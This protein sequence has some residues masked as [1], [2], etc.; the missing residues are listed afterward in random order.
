[1]L[2]TL[3]T[4]KEKSGDH[5]AMPLF[6]TGGTDNSILRIMNCGKT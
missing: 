3:L 4:W 2:H 1:M 5:G 6:K